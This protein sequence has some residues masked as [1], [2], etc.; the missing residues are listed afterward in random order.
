[1]TPTSIPIRLEVISLLKRAA[2]SLILLLLMTV[3]AAGPARAEDLSEMYFAVGRTALSPAS[4]L[5]SL[6]LT[7][8]VSDQPRIGGLY[9]DLGMEYSEEA[10]WLDAGFILRG[11]EKLLVITPYMGAGLTY[12][13]SGFVLPGKLT[14]YIKYG[15]EFLW[16]YW[17][18]EI[19]ILQAA[20][21][22]IHR[23][24]LRVGF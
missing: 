18:E 4:D 16:F 12:Q 22:I 8:L 11:G 7:M 23:A 6:E 17:E 21:D 13:A 5:N 14:P 24:G 3:A 1:M 19:L 20:P 10:L 2:F 15:G 9:L